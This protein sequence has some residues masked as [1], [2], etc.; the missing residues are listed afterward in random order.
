MF[1]NVLRGVILLLITAMVY[2]LSV[3]WGVYHLQHKL[4]PQTVTDL[5]V[6]SQIWWLPIVTAF[7]IGSFRVLVTRSVRPFFFLVCKD[8]ED[9]K[10][11]ETRVY[12]AS[13]AS[14]KLFWYSCMSVWAYMLLKDTSI[15]P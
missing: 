5:P 1:D 10:A 7:A 15:W 3:V 9:K 6:F 13:T 12:K 4:K 11:F 8:K 2:F 14:F